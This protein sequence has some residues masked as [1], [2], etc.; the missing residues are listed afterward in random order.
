MSPCIETRLDRQVQVRNG[1]QRLCYVWAYEDWYGPIPEGM[2][3]NHLCHNPKCYNVEHLYAGTQAENMRDM[4]EAG[5]HWNQ[6]KTHCKHGHEFT[7][8]NTYVYGVRRTCKTC[9]KRR[10]AERYELQRQA[11]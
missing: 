7:E 2:Q 10:A 9:A 3:V 6:Q 5:R 8:E 1:V 11:I 4:C